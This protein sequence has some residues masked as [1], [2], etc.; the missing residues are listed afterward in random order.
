MILQSAD[1]CI[2]HPSVSVSVVLEGFIEN[3]NST[4][5]SK[6]SSE[7]L[8]CD[9]GNGLCYM[10]LDY[11]RKKQTKAKW[12]MINMRCSQGNDNH[13]DMKEYLKSPPVADVRCSRG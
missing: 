7:Q 2:K 4:A 11:K 10:K 1:K 5:A 9:G 12:P 8:Y 13:A 3:N 6:M